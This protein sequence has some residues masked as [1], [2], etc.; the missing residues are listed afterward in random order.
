MQFASLDFC[1]VAKQSSF[2]VFCAFGS[3]ARVT[4]SSSVLVWFNSLTSEPRDTLET[5]LFA[6]FSVCAG[7]HFPPR[8]MTPEASVEYESA[9]RDRLNLRQGKHESQLRDAGLLDLSDVHENPGELEVQEE[10]T[11][12]RTEN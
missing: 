9:Q 7:N 10:S 1:F 3:T 5:S 4:S 8:G 6:A 11:P 12:G 2:Y